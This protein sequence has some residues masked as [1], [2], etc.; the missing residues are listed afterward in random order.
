MQESRMLIAKSVENL[1]CDEE[2]LLI[3]PPTLHLCR[4]EIR[5][6]DGEALIRDLLAN[7][8]QVLAADTIVWVP[9]NGMSLTRILEITT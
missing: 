8:C 9:E 6:Q 1:K 7:E 5:F 3:A 4:T 2:F